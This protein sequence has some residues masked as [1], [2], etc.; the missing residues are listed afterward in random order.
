MYI[1]DSETEL[2][3]LITKE[4]NLYFE[5]VKRKYMKTTKSAQNISRPVE[6]LVIPKRRHV[7]QTWF[8]ANSIEYETPDEI[9]EPLALEFGITLDVAATNKNA[10]CKNYFTAEDNGLLKDWDG[11]CWMNPPYGRVMKKWVEKAY[12]EYLKGNTIIC[13]LPAR[14]NTNWWHEFIIP[15]AE[16][17]FIKGQVKFKGFKRCLW[18]PMAI[19]IFKPF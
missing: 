15:N 18:M 7:K 12:N 5:K 17:R 2:G 1:V 6:P 13:L 19:V 10:K 3:K 14:T 8:N 9:F 4:H 16:I 11:V